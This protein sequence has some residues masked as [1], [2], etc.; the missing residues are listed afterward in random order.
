MQRLN[1]F[2]RDV[3]TC[4]WCNKSLHDSQSIPQLAHII[5]QNKYNIKKYGKIIIHNPLNM[6]SVC[7]LKCNAKFD[8]GVKNE[9]IEKLVALIKES[10]E[11]CDSVQ[12]TGSIDLSEILDYNS[13]N[14]NNNE[15]ENKSYF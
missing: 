14:E 11:R 8:I 7:G 15:S 2:Q 1:I 6:M 5:P 3:F 9:L 4:R 12:D 10:I 13:K